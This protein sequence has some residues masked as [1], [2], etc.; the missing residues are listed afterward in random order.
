MALELRLKT[1]LEF[2]QQPLQSDCFTMSAPGIAVQQESDLLPTE[3]RVLRVLLY[4]NIFNHPL[5]AGE[6]LAFLP[7]TESSIE[8]L[9]DLLE[10]EAL[11]RHIKRHGDYFLLRSAPESSVEQRIFKESVARRRLVVA[12]FV[13]RFI[14]LF[15][16][17]RCV[18]LSGELSKGVASK[19]SD[20]DFVVVTRP[21]RL[22][23]CRSFLILF[24]K[25]V[26]LNSRRYFCL[27]H[28]VAEDNL[29]VGLRNIYSA[30][31]IATL[32]PLYNRKRYEE[33]MANN[34]WI[35]EYFPN[36]SLSSRP[37]VREQLPS[38]TVRRRPLPS[39]VIDRFDRWLMHRWRALWQVR[40]ANLDREELHHKFRCDVS[41]STAYGVDYQRKVLAQ[42]AHKLRQYGIVA[43]GRQS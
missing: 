28:F 29:E 37:V 32:K 1:C 42:Y 40:Y 12:S 16:Y 8:E 21:G 3:E 36:L 4:F 9:S 27:N 2:N 19:N 41:L 5:T 43:V 38:A 30:T 18:M 31:E 39:R 35:K 7:E 14:G 6:I 24:K 33:Y 23:L 11:R 22:W 26:L 20:I 13:A 25:T 34:V 17:V 15:P 10:S